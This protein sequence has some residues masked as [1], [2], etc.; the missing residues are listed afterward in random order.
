MSCN[1]C[2]NSSLEVI[3]SRDEFQ[4]LFGCGAEPLF[5]GFK[6]IEGG[7]VGHRLFSMGLRLD[8]K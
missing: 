3:S 6:V 2:A 1:T 5:N 7:F 8:K 4:V